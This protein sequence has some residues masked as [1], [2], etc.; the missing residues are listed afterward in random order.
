MQL[1]NGN[2]T[3]CGAPGTSLPGVCTEF[4]LPTEVSSVQFVAQAS[5]PIS[6]D[7]F[8][9]AGS[10]ANGLVGATGSPDLWAK[11]VA[12]DTVMASLSVPEVPYGAWI[13]VPADK[14]PYSASGAPT[15]P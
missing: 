8:N 14:G 4:F 3:A 11:Q 2:P 9:D 10:G 1:Q 6:M 15:V 13:V 7:A 12:P 5:A